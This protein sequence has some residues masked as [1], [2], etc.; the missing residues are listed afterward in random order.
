[1]GGGGF[2]NFPPLRRRGGCFLEGGDLFERGG[3]LIEDLQYSDQYIFVL[4]K[5]I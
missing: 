5:L 3:G 1:M 4:T 2:I